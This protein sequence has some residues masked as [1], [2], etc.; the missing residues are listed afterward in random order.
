MTGPRVDFET[1]AD[2]YEHLVDI[3]QR[4]SLQLDRLCRANGIRY[5]HFLQPNQYVD[6]SKLLTADERSQAF[7]EDHP[8]RAGV[9]MGYPLLVRA[10]V[11]LSAQGVRFVDLTRVFIDEESTLYVDDCCHFNEAGNR[12]I[13]ARVT[14][15]LLTD[16]N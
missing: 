5:Y 15:E 6:G 16:T 9:E 8:Y 1:D 13:A 10:G 11:D 4:S 14:H 7:T 12:L 2:L 3:W